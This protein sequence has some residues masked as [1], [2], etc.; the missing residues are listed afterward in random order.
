MHAA[1]VR[2][3]SVCVCVCVC[4]GKD[5]RKMQDRSCSTP[6]VRL[7]SPP[8]RGA[9]PPP[10]VPNRPPFTPGRSADVPRR[11]WGGWWGWLFSLNIFGRSYSDTSARNRYEPCVCACVCVAAKA[12][13]RGGGGLHPPTNILSRAQPVVATFV[14]LREESRGAREG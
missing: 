10:P 13:T 14:H 8:K 9:H 2:M 1:G 12:R 5:E 6:S 3:L 11:T 4:R 7:S